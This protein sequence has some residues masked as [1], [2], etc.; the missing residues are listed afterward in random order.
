MVWG[1]ISAYGVGSLQIWKG[2]INAENYIE[3]L[4]QHMLPSRQC[5]FQ[6]RPCI[7]QQDNAKP[8][9]ASIT[10]AWLHRRRVWVLNWPP[11]SPDLSPIKT[12][13]CIIVSS[14][15]PDVYR[16]L[17]KEE[18]LLHCYTMVN[19]TLFQLFSDV[20]LPSNLK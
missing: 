16:Q 3:V 1:C 15:F 14:H 6:E 8:H 20:L 17:L 5:L 10:T 13:R 12:F 9:T 2:T 4:E 7:V 11:C 19:I 18:G